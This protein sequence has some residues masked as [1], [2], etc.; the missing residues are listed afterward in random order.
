[1]YLYWRNTCAL[2]RMT[3]S[4]DLGW[5]SMIVGQRTG[6]HLEVKV[7]NLRLRNYR[8]CVVHVHVHMY[9]IAPT[10]ATATYETWTHIG[11]FGLV[12]IGSKLFLEPIYVRRLTFSTARHGQHARHQH[13]TIY[14]SLTGVCLSEQCRRHRRRGGSSSSMEW[15]PLPRLC[16]E[17]GK[18]SR[19]MLLSLRPWFGLPF[20]T[21]YFCATNARRRHIGATIRNENG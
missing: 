2:Y 9:V 4:P 5:R 7:S 19:E 16:S 11:I 6:F 1:M 18:H 12:T 3:S 15:Q 8:S 13:I 21:A 17:F 14:I 10:L 20:P